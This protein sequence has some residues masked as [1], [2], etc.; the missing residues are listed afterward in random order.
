MG[1]AHLALSIN[2]VWFCDHEKPNAFMYTWVRQYRRI[3]G[4]RHAQLGYVLQR[5]GIHQDLYGA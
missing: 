1:H 2:G 5:V 3:S 4:L